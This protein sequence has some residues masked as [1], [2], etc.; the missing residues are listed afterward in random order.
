MDQADTEVHQPRDDKSI[1]YG[2]YTAYRCIYWREVLTRSVHD[3]QF[4]WGEVALAFQ[5]IAI[6][7]V[8]RNAMAQC[9]DTGSGYKESVLE[10]WG[11]DKWGYFLW[12]T[13]KL[14][15]SWD[16]VEPS[17]FHS[18]RK[19]SRGMPELKTQVYF[20]ATRR[21]PDKDLR[22]RSKQRPLWNHLHSDEW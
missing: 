18:M 14:M 2:P 15:S 20:A 10:D 9:G 16:L 1:P 8:T 4:F 12:L 17:F 22:G 13:H 7:A 21:F 6:L 3:P 19:H 5:M 11:Y